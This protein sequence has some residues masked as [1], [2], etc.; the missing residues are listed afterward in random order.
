MDWKKVVNTTGYSSEECFFHI[1][2]PLQKNKYRCADVPD[3]DAMNDIAIIYSSFAG[4]TRAVSKYIAEKI[5]ADTFDLKQ[6]SNIDL[7]FYNTIILGTGV[8]AGKPYRRLTDFV[9]KN[10][11]AL[12]DKQV[13]LFVCCI[14]NGQKA[15]NQVGNIA[16][17]YGITNAVYFSS[18]SEKNEAKL[19]KDVDVFIERVR[20]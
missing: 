18:S 4:K 8:H 12:R 7:S 5:G 19:S 1:F 20:P 2:R 14:Y 15:D 17:G 9:E 10:R 13:Y 6:Q 16:S 3:R 11:V